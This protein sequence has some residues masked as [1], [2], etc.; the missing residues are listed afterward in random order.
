MMNMPVSIMKQD[1]IYYLKIE[2]PLGAMAACAT[3]QGICC[4]EFTDQKIIK[5]QEQLSDDFNV[6]EN[7]NPHLDRLKIELAEY[8]AG[9]RKTFSVALHPMGTPF[10]QQ[11]W[12]ALLGIP[13]GTTTTYQEQSV[14]LGNPKSIRAVASANGKNPI[15]I[16]IP[17]H[18][19]IGKNGDLTGY[20]GGLVRKKWL[21]DH[22]RIHAGLSVQLT[23]MTGFASE[24]PAD[25]AE[26]G[27]RLVKYRT[28]HRQISLFGTPEIL[29]TSLLKPSPFTLT[30][31]LL[32]HL[33]F[34][35]L[36]VSCSLFVF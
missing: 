23:F 27:N 21:L 33:L 11:V 15:A 9:T 32:S 26:G 17:C 29:K 22:E 14:K 12:N 28:A 16:L 5:N 25:N 7:P 30:V 18:R 31:W 6:V 8:F 19:V 10:Q 35:D 3:D 36:V 4:L 2:T 13:Y 20:A 1:T 24:F 34:P